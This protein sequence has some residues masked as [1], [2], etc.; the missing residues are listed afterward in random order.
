MVP[1]RVTAGVRRAREVAKRVGEA[2]AVHTAQ[3]A[4]RKDAA[5]A[6]RK[7][8]MLGEAAADAAAVAAEQRAVDA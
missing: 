3:T 6:T 4:A 5:A 7:G 1:R 8:R 2:E